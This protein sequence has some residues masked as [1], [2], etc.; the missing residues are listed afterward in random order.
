MKAGLKAIKTGAFKWSADYTEGA[1]HFQKAA[2]I[3]KSLGQKDKAMECYLKFSMCS[4]KINEM[5]GAADGL[6]E[7]AF[8]ESDKKRS[9]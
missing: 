8:L 1:M 3:F 7:A 4:E 2:K 9:F 5:Y 6:A